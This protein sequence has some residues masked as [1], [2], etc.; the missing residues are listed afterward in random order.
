MK[1]IYSLLICLFCLQATIAAQ[2]QNDPYCLYN[3]IGQLNGFWQDSII[4][5]LSGK[6]VQVIKGAA[7]V[8]SSGELCGWTDHY[9]FFFDKDGQ[10][11]F[12]SLKP[13]AKDKERIHLTGDVS[14]FVP[15]WFIDAFEPVLCYDFLPLSMAEIASKN[16]A[17]TAARQNA[18]WDRGVSSSGGYYTD[19]STMGKGARQWMRNGL[20]GLDDDRMS[21]WQQYNTLVVR[22]KDILANAVILPLTSGYL[23]FNNYNYS[24]TPVTDKDLLLY[25]RRQ[26]KKKNQHREDLLLYFYNPGNTIVIQAGNEYAYARSCF[27]SACWYYKQRDYYIALQWT[28]LAARK[29]ERYLNAYVLAAA[30]ARELGNYDIALDYLSRMDDIAYAEQLEALR[31]EIY[32]LQG[33]KNKAVRSVQKAMKGRGEDWGLYMRNKYALGDML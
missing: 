22:N 32:F 24:G 5:S 6:P 2:E 10:L 33:D 25:R 18:A 13:S 9:G 31:A 3:G 30:C 11:L 27:D 29:R 28:V 12:C 1:C 15:V 21:Q 23:K 14:T 20:D 26:E 19:Y 17:I 16:M 7:V 4:Y 8:D